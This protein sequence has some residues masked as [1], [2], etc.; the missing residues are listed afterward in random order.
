[1]R[2]GPLATWRG[3]MMAM[4]RC[5]PQ[6]ASQNSARSNMEGGQH[7]DRPHPEAHTLTHLAPCAATGET[8]HTETLASRSTV[9][10]KGTHRKWAT[11]HIDTALTKCYRNTVSILPYQSIT[12]APYACNECWRSSYGLKHNILDDCNVSVSRGAK[13]APQ[14]ATG[15]G[16]RRNMGHIWISGALGSDRP[17]FAIKARYWC[18]GKTSS[19]G[20]TSSNDPLGERINRGTRHRKS[21]ALQRKNGDPRVFVRK[22]LIRAFRA[23]PC[24][25]FYSTEAELGGATYPSQGRHL[26]TLGAADIQ[27]SAEL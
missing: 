11:Q 20:Q 2:R 21:S 13:D 17:R 10:A 25:P 19:A 12:Q 9:P 7:N 8:H 3:A 27:S 1:M 15:T 18:W 24:S 16:G 14:H 26:E 5:M 22:K 6:V 23:T 4:R